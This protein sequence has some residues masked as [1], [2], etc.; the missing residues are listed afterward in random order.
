MCLWNVLTL[1]NPVG[2]C[3]KEA[4]SISCVLKLFQGLIPHQWPPLYCLVVARASVSYVPSCVAV[5][6]TVWNQAHTWADCHSDLQPW[7][8][9]LIASLRIH[10][11][12]SYS[13]GLTTGQIC[14][15]IL[16]QGAQNSQLWRICMHA[17]MHLNTVTYMNINREFSVVPVVIKYEG[18]L[19]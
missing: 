9:L 5:F 3:Q 19:L 16:L 11:L 8:N 4:L 1:I 13:I 10:I 12:K 6:L 15:V 17:C 14:V 18:S 2:L 7:I